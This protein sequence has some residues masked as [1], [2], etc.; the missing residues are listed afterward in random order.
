M[1]AR[2]RA[3]RNDAQEQ[4]SAAAGSPLTVCASVFS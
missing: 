3:L 1:M 2:L 4:E